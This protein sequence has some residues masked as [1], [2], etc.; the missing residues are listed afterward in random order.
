MVQFA[1]NVVLNTSLIMTKSIQNK[2]LWDA[3]M[4][5]LLEAL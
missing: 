4:I 5:N 3:Y 2:T 1:F